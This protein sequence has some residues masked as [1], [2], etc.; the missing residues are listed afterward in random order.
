MSTQ[1]NDQ[2]RV[3]ALST[4]TLVLS[5]VAG[6]LYA[7]PKVAPELLGT[8]LSFWLPLVP[9]AFALDITIALMVVR[10]RK[11]SGGRKAVF[12]IVLG[13]LATAVIL[14]PDLI[15][16]AQLVLSFIHGKTAV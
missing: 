14:V 12:A 5:L 3:G 15:S 8:A 9:A 10:G 13:L 11:R 4:W 1:T 6:V 2:S 7:V 16:L